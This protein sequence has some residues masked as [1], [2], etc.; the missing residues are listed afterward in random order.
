MSGFSRMVR[1]RAMRIC[2]PAEKSPQRLP[3][4]SR[5][6][7]RPASTRSTCSSRRWYP[8]ASRRSAI[9]GVPVQ[10]AGG[11][12]AP[13]AEP[14]KA[15]L[16]GPGLVE[17][18]PARGEGGLRLLAQR[19]VRRDDA[20]LGHVPDPGFALADDLAGIGGREADHDAK[21]RGLAAAVG[22]HEGHPRAGCDV[23]V[24]GVEELPGAEGDRHPLEADE[25]HGTEFRA[26]GRR[27]SPPARSLPGPRP[28]P[29]R[30]PGRG[31][32]GARRPPRSSRGSSPR[33][34]RRR[35]AG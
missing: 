22:P 30:R 14:G 29:R 20:G 34:P 31:R 6:K 21:E 11:F 12:L 7:P 23:E 19:A 24:D 33:P 35:T 9:R 17:Q 5:A 8:E 26:T 15:L 4:S 27:R 13:V 10:E 3:P 1:A 16:D 25:C 2:Q 18:R 32:S 28:A